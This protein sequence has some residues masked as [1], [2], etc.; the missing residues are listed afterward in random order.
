MSKPAPTGGWSDPGR[1]DWYLNQVG[2][3]PPR[4]AGEEVLRSV[5]PAEPRSLL[6]L[7]C[8][9]GRLTALALDACPTLG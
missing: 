4:L 8:G 7:G 2:N 9:D 5:L 3:L 1:V 6:D